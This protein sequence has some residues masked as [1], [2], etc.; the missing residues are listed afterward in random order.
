MFVVAFFGCLSKH[1]GGGSVS[2]SRLF[3]AFTVTSTSVYSFVTFNKTEDICSG[4][5]SRPLH[6]YTLRKP[7]GT[8]Q[9]V[10]KQMGILLFG[11]EFVR[12]HT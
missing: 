2:S 5:G 8:A 9:S 10:W 12:V 11:P 3:T 1:Q 7:K 4:F 6:I